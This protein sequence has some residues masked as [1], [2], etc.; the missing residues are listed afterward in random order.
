MF[1]LGVDPLK[2]RIL[3]LLAACTPMI[4]FARSL[5]GTDYFAQLTSE[6]K[7]TRMV[8]GRPQI[9]FE[10][11][12]AARTEALDCCVYA[13][14][15]RASLQIDL[16]RREQDLS[17]PVPPPAPPPQVIKSTWMAR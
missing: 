3:G 16:D 1:I 11:K 9:R 17:A 6:R 15:A 10:R 14:A 12:P 4:K 7:V 13:L 2:S 5:A 8:R